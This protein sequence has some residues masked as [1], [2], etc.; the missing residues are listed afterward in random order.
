MTYA[1]FQ[2]D[3][4]E[5]AGAEYD[6]YLSLPPDE[7]L[8][9]VKDRAYGECYQLWR[10][11]ATVATLVDAGPVLLEVTRR[12]SEEYLIRYH[13]AS[14]LLTL[15][16]TSDF[17]AVHLAKESPQRAANLDVVEGVLRKQL[18]KG[19]SIIPDIS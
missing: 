19:K 13:A 18:E 9:A 6:W 2:K 16:G 10:A 15:L 11:I 8:W 12:D 3:W 7:L 17:E 14:A 1:E 5:A 4:E